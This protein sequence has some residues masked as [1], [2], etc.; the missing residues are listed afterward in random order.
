[1]TLEVG[2]MMGAGVAALVAGLVLV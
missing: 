1:M 2:G